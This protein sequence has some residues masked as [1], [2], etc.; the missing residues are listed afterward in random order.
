MK[1]NSQEGNPMKDHHYFASCALGWKTADTRDEA[2]KGL[3]AGFRSDLKRMT[4]NL[5]KKGELGAY[6]WS[7]K[8]LADKTAK[9]K[10]NFFAPEGVEIEEGLHHHIT[11]LTAKET[12][13]F[14]T[15]EA[16]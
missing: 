9:Y 12:A 4:A 8:V 10:I 6:I 14:T 5:H 15:K 16:L 11:Y 7:C 3:V 1:R 13:Y 2:I